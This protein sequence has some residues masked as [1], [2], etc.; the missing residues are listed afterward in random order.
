MLG[1]REN[2]TRRA[3]NLAVIYNSASKY[4]S[5]TVNTSFFS[6]LS[7]KI[8]YFLHHAQN[9][10]AFFVNNARGKNLFFYCKLFF[11]RL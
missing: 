5:Q 10:A 4:L 9:V 3:Q 11:R 2:T 6:S 7:V 1:C 8:L